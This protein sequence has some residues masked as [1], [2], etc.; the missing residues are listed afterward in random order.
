[1]QSTISMHCEFSLAGLCQCSWGW[2]CLVF[3]SLEPFFSFSEFTIHRFSVP[4]FSELQAC[5]KYSSSTLSFFR[6]DSEPENYW[7]E[8][9]S[10]VMYM[11]KGRN[12]DK[13][14]IWC[15]T[16][17]IRRCLS[18]LTKSVILNTGY[19]GIPNIYNGYSTR[20]WLIRRKSG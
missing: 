19:S 6:W 20:H 4:Y 13:L 14:G 9:T 15:G 2:M 18:E 12:I 10:L 8:V 7:L 5:L 11:D 3:T 1:M 17:K 16:D